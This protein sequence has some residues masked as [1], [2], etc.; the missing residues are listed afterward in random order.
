M[1]HCSKGGF[2]LG[3]LFVQKSSGRTEIVQNVHFCLL[4]FY[5]LKN[6]SFFFFTFPFSPVASGYEWNYRNSSG[7]LHAIQCLFPWLC[8]PCFLSCAIYPS[9]IICAIYPCFLSCAIYLYFFSCAIYS[10]FLSC[11]IYPS[12]C[13][14]SLLNTSVL[15]QLH[16]PFKA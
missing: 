9:F 4:L 2:F 3:V 14:D 7:I 13:K 8:Y 6:N 10:C 11:A 12:I 15:K 1:V 5:F 16:I